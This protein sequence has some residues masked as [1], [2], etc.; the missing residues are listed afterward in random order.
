MYRDPFPERT[1]REVRR[2][3][4]RIERERIPPG[5]DPQF[6]LKLGRGSLSDIEFTV[7][8]LQLAHGAAHPEV[9]S[10]ATIE[11]LH[12]LRDAGF[13]DARTP[14][15]SKTRTG[16]VSAPATRATSSRENPVTRSRRVTSRRTWRGS[17][18][19]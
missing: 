17:W 3:K 8:L 13:L 7:Q 15:R 18:G 14:R 19:I 11:A 9:R 4:V 1:A 5:E 16:S 12:R 2:M 10:A 6:H